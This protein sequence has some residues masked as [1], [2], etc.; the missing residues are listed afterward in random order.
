MT[1]ATLC[2]TG[3][4]VHEPQGHLVSA[5]DAPSFVNFYAACAAFF[6]LDRQPVGDSLHQGVMYRHQDDRGRI[7]RVRVAADEVAIG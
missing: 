7:D 4:T 3:R 5:G 1:E 6:W 2:Q